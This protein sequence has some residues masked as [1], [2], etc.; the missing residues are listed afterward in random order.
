MRDFN[1]ERKL[2]LGGLAV[3][4]VADVG[5]AY[6]NSRLS[7]A[8]EIPA[9]QMLAAQSRQVALMRAD[10]QKA[11]A[12]RKGIPEVTKGFNEFESSLPPASKGYS[13]ITQEIDDIA[14]DTHVVIEDTKFHEKDLAGRNL[15]ELEF[16]STI[17]GDYPG[18]VRFLNKL[19]R[20]KNAY[21]VD[22]L[23]L[24]SANAAQ[25]PNAPLKVGLHLRT[26]FRKA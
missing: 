15:S 12:I 24:D 10:I 13:V 6:F 18:I 3:F 22:S 8:R 26:Y 14:K 7:A 20:S 4:L 17:S 25:T 11:T 2:I 9:E 21:I 19:Q 5:F 23:Q 1:L 16:E